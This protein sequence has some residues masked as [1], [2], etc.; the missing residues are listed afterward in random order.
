MSLSAWTAFCGEE[1]ITMNDKQINS[2]TVWYRSVARA[3]L[4]YYVLDLL[5][6][7]FALRRD[8]IEMTIPEACLPFL[9]AEV[10]AD[11]P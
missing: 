4:L 5:C 9:I 11:P 1:T 6:Q 3:I 2:K 8:R 10:M 7:E